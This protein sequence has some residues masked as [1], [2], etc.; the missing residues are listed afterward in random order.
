VSELTTGMPLPELVIETST[1]TPGD[2]QACAAICGS[3]GVR[4]VEAA[5]AGGTAGMAAGTNLFLV[6]GSDEDVEL[7]R[8]TIEA[9]A[10]SVQHLGPVGTG[11]A[12]KVVNNAVMHAVMV[13]LIEASAMAVRAGLPMQTV[14]DLMRA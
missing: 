1:V 13:V 3:A 11:M 4:F 8:P 2:A 12:A 7:A 5:I 9:M 10:G 6:G 14:V